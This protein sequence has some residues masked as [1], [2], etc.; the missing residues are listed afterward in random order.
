M[1]SDRIREA[2]DKQ[3]TNWKACTLPVTRIMILAERYS[4][5]MRENWLRKKRMTHSE[6]ENCCRSRQ[7]A[8]WCRRTRPQ[9]YWQAIQMYWFVHLGVTSELNPVGFIQSGPPGSASESVL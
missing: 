2:L 7:T 8:K 1:I 4:E 6:K 5:L 9:T 3:R